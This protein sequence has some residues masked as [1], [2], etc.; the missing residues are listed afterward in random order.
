MPGGRQRVRP[1]EA[2]LLLQRLDEYVQLRYTT[3][4]DFER[5]TKTPHATADKWRLGA[6]VPD[7]PQLLRLAKRDPLLDLHHLLTG[8]RATGWLRAEELHGLLA[9]LDAAMLQSRKLQSKWRPIGVQPV[10]G[11]PR[12]RKTQRRRKP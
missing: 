5:K 1:A 11:R 6:A 3:W 4:P 7:L 12:K 2:R 8:R 10:P 9:N